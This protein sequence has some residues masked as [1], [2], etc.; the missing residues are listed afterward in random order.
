MANNKLGKQTIRFD[1]PPTIL[2]AASIVGPKEGE[3]PL[4]TFFDKVECDDKCNEST[5]EK[6][7]EYF[8]YE[9]A[10]LLLKKENLKNSDI[11][12][13][14]SGDLLNQIISS[15]FTAKKLKIPYFGVYAACSTF[16]EGMQLASFI[17]S[18]GFAEKIV[19]SASSHFSSAE[20]QYRSPLESGIQ[21]AMTAQWTIT[22]AGNIIIAKKTR[23]PYIT[24]ITTGIVQDYG[25]KDANNMGTAMAPAAVE[26]IIAHFN[27]TGYKPQDYDLIIT[28]DLGTIGKEITRDLLVREGLDVSMNYTDCG[29]E[30]FDDSQDTHARGSGAGCSAVVFSGYLFDKLNKKQFNKILFVPT[31]ALL[32]PTSTLQGDTI[33]CIAHAVTIENYPTLG[34][35]EN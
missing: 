31:G 22:G 26:T 28:G 30:I 32:S 29:V 34:R 12:Y 19:V 20:R 8:A 14:I 1:N 15:N 18:G 21:R 9:S 35:K 10:Q 3:G 11:D 23:P 25:I 13:Y 24:H 4:S 33:P 7:E 16:A 5:F 27:D 17:I 6:A 2:N